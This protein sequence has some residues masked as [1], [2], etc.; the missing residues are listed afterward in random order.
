MLVFHAALSCLII[1]L[2]D[3]FIMCTFEWELILDN[4]MLYLME[5]DNETNKKTYMYIYLSQ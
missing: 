5:F 1:S 4:I 3:A 2:K